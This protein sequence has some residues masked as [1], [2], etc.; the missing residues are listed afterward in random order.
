MAETTSSTPN[1]KGLRLEGVINAK[2]LF[3][4]P[5]SGDT[6]YFFHVISPGDPLVHKVQVDADEWSKTP[7]NSPFREAVS[8]RSFRDEVTL[9]PIRG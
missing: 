6:V 2:T 8:Y 9:Y 3:K 5:K 7:E 1:R 4:Y